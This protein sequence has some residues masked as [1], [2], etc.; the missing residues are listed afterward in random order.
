MGLSRRNDSNYKRLPPKE[1]T[2][3][4]L[5]KTELTGQF[6][7]YSSPE[8]DLSVGISQSIPFPYGIQCAQKSYLAETQLQQGKVKLQ[9]NELKQQVRTLYQQLQYLAFKQQQL[10]QLD[11][12]FNDFIRIAQVRFK[13]GDTKKID[14]NTAQVKK[15]RLPSC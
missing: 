13:A 5:P 4:E 8:K 3:W 1:R 11:S 6:G 2:A 14:I 7:Q 10:L 9:E 15:E 12:L